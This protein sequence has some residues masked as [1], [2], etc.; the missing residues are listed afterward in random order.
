V[1]GRGRAHRLDEPLPFLGED[2]YG[3]FAWMELAPNASNVGFIVHR[4]NAKDGTEADRFFD[5]S[6]NPEIWLKQDDATVYTSQAA[7]QGYATVHYRNP[8]GDYADWGL[9]LWGDAIGGDVATEWD[10]PRPPDGSDDFGLFWNVPI[11]DATQPLNFII[12]RGDEKDPGPDQSF[13]PADDASVWIMSGDETI[14]AEKGGAL[15]FATIHYH[16]PDGDYGDYTSE[17]FN[18]FWGLHVWTG[19]AQPNPSWQQPVKPVRMDL[20]G[21]V[22][23]IPLVDG[24]QELNYILHR[25]DTKDPGPDQSL[26][27]T[28][29]GYEVWQL[30]GADPED[31]YLLPMPPSGPVSKG[32]LKEQ[33]AYWVSQDTILWPAADD[34]SATY[35]LHYAAAGG[36]EL[37]DEACRAPASRWC[38]APP[39][40]PTR[41]CTRSSPT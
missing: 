26:N 25:G 35:A 11:V 15:G 31:P 23:E 13:V 39:A 27:V 4:G 17:D 40:R 9:H 41:P 37:T 16:R 30:Q 7:A 12:H 5:P 36:L 29:I 18:D 34:P 8:G 20:F 10:A 21:P 33:K 28:E 19:A 22:F 6:R 32:N 38:G 14:H 3:R 24:A 1:G 2:E